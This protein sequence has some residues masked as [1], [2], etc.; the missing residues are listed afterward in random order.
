MDGRW[1]TAWSIAQCGIELIAPKTQGRTIRIDITE[2]ISGSKIRV[3]TSNRYGK[4]SVEIG[5]LCIRLENRTSIPILFDG[6]KEL[7][8]LPGQSRMSDPVDAT[9]Q[10]GETIT[11]SIYYPAH[12]GKPVC[13]N[14]DQ[15]T[16][17]SVKGNFS[18]TEDFIIQP[19]RQP[20]PKV[21]GVYIPEPLTILE[22]I[23]VFTEEKAAGIVAFG[24]SITQMGFWVNPLRVRLYRDYPGKVALLNRGISGNRM[25]RDGFRMF[26]RM[27]GEAGVKRMAWDVFELS[28]ISSVILALGIN[29][30]AQPFAS[31]R[32]PDQS[33]IC[34]F[35]DL[36]EGYKKIVN[37]CHDRDFKVIGCTIT[38]F[39]GNKGFKPETESLRTSVN[40]WILQSGVFDKTM[41]YACWVA[42]PERPS[43]LHR[44]YD[45][46]DHLHPNEKGGKAIANRIPSHL[47]ME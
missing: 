39:G 25:L 15:K 31:K 42:D 44:E 6:K 12:Q 14:F 16:A 4:K 21:F 30:I 1:I 38:P 34:S 9:I 11:A 33:E 45:L 26:K 43:F 7:L 41:D 8:L 20:L 18:D 23:D 13:G 36:I 19:Y 5:G 2:N 35:D 46:G 27:F 17:H 22:G 28:G 32:P 47:I 3:K 40:Q 10:A 37:T 29:D 24:D